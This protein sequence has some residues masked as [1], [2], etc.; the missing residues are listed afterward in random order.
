MWNVIWN[1]GAFSFSLV[2]GFFLS[3]FVI[4]HL[5][6]AGYGVWVLML[7]VTSYLGFFDL[8]VRGAVTRYVSKFHT[9][10]DHQEASRIASSATGI[11][12][13]AGALAILVA[14][15]LALV[16]VDLFQIPPAYHQPAR[17]VLLLSGITMAVTLI[18]GVFG[19]ILVGLQR[20]DL[21]NTIGVLST[22]LRALATVLVLRAGRGIVALAWIQLIFSVVPVIASAYLSLRLY[23]QL[24][25]SM[26]H[27][28]WAPVSLIFSFSVVSF[29]CNVSQQVIYYT[30]AVVIGIFLPVGLITFFSIAGN[31]MNYARALISGISFTMTPLASSLEAAGKN[32]RLQQVALDAPRYATALMLPIAATFIV[33]GQSFIRLWMGPE[34]AELSGRVLW[35][36]SLALLFSAATQVLASVMFGISR[37]RVM[38]VAVLVEAVCN[39]AASVA[40]V[41][42]IGIVGVAWATTIPNLA[43][44]LLFWPWYVRRTLGIPIRSYLL[45]IWVR[46]GLAVLPFVLCT[47]MV[48]RFWTA[49]SLVT[50]CLQV[51]AVLPFA[52]VG[53]WLICFTRSERQACAR[54]L[55]QPLMQVLGG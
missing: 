31:L 52:A 22:G 5:G 40:L 47:Y 49:A 33:R 41:R 51:V 21:S 25:I 27:F 10:G 30:D 55:F 12:L 17:S 32:Q 16:A 23:P 4:H 50:F 34:Y 11:F 53:L 13:I 7:S 14:L 46:P 6:D 2:I 26:R 1:W 39:L 36:L 48:D 9:Q 37:H 38:M 43:A 54:N 42:V 28:A 8:G 35:I 45:S 15:V 20:F 44:S 29:L 19:G 3:P 24:R 18:G